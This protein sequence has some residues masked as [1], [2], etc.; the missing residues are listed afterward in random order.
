MGPVMDS[1]KDCDD[2]GV[3]IELAHQQPV[4]LGALLVEPGLRRVVRDDG[5]EEFLE[6]RV[7]QLFVA[8]LGAN[9]RILS[10]DELIQCCWEGRIVGDDAINRTL[11]RLRRLAEGLYQSSVTVTRRGLS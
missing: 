9:G 1:T 5:A 11:S 4:R 10:R 8:F 6:P 3:R 2:N 7:M